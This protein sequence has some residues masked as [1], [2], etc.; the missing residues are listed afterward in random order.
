MTYAWRRFVAFIL[1]APVAFIGTT[2][3]SLANIRL[4]PADSAWAETLRLN[5]L[6]AY[7]KF[8]MDYPD[9]KYA[10]QAYTKLASDGRSADRADALTTTA[11]LDLGLASQ[12]D[13]V[14]GTIMVV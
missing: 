7:T 14:P 5:T 1:A 4:S 10:N 6:E 13:L 8:A 11:Y 12:P 2:T 9:S 3:A